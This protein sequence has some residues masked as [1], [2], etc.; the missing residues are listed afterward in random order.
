LIDQVSNKADVTKKGK[1]MK[2]INWLAIILVI[3]AVASGYAASAVH[4]SS[5]W[6]LPMFLLC[7]GQIITL[8]VMVIS[9]ACWIG[10]VAKLKNFYKID[11]LLLKRAISESKSVRLD[12]PRLQDDKATSTAKELAYATLSVAVSERISELTA[13]AIEYNRQLTELRAYNNNIFTRYFVPI[14]P[15]ELELINLDR[16]G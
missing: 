2:R 7:I 12:T 9:R 14:P 15:D 11:L 16:I 1:N 5:D 6:E 13:K 4:Y 10:E 3:G 8:V